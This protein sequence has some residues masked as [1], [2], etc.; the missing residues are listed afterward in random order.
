MA[1]TQGLRSL[2]PTDNRVAKHRHLANIIKDIP[3]T[4]DNVA[5]STPTDQIVHRERFFADR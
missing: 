3:G 1:V 2:I 4:Q 5:F